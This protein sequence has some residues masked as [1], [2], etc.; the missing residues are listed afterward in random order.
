VGKKREKKR[1]EKEGRKERAQGIVQE[2][3]DNWLGKVMI[4]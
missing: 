4:V 2:I 1:E 3:A